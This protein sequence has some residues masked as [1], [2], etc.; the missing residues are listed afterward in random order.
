MPNLYKTFNGC[1]KGFYKLFYISFLLFLCFGLVGN[2][3]AQSTITPGEIEVTLQPGQCV[4]QLVTIE[5]G[6][7]PIPKLDVVLVIDVTGSMAGVIGEVTRS[8]ETIANDVRAVVPDTQFALVTLADYAGNGGGLLSLFV[9]YGAPGD[10]P[11]RLDQDFTPDMQLIQQALEDIV[12]LHGGDDPESYLRA[13]YEAQF[14][15]WRSG[16]RRIVILFGDVNAHD[17]DPGRDATEG[18]ADD[19]TQ[20]VVLTDL[21]SNYITVLAIYTNVRY[22]TF[23]DTI[24]MDTG[25]QAFHLYATDQVAEVVQ[26]LVEETVTNIQV[27]SLAVDS[28]QSAWLTWEPGLYRD[29]APEAEYDF[30]VQACAPAGTAPGDYVFDLSATG[31]GAYLSTISGVV[32][33]VA[34]TPVPLPGVGTLSW[35]WL[36]IPLLLLTGALLWYFLRPRESVS[37]VRPGM[38]NGRPSPPPSKPK[39]TKPPSGSNITHNKPPARKN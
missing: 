29:V 18:T 38:R 3:Q 13:L 25:G 5:I 20:N 36:L 1:T 37:T 26:A 30:D 21:A 33:V 4:E 32:H 15:S 35:W 24:A 2:I 8:A 28:S 9:E 11:W 39:T 16:A 6:E 22:Q 19:L 23:Y 34:D 12:L 17:P 27:V 31:D 14:L 7:A 10:Y